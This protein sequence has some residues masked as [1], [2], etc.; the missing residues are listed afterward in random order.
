MGLPYTFQFL[1][2]QDLNQPLARFEYDRRK[3]PASS[4]T[5]DLYDAIERRVTNRQPFDGTMLAKATLETLQVTAQTHGGFCQLWSLE[6]PKDKK[7]AAQILGKADR[8]RLHHKALHRQLF[9]ELRW[10][11]KAAERSQ[12]GIDIQTLELS[13][14]ALLA[15]ATLSRYPIARTFPRK[16][17][18]ALPASALL[19]CSHFCCLGL[20]QSITPETLFMAGRVLQQ[21]WLKATCLE[22]ALQ[23][24]TVLPFFLIRAL[25]FPGTGFNPQEE[26]EINALGKDLRNL[27]RLPQESFPLFLFRLSQAAPPSTRSLR[28]DWDTFTVK[29]A[30]L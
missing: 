12:D 5:A 6:D 22:L 17:V 2:Y 24:W 10:N 9:G 19:G 14:P 1:G 23:P 11:R 18:E 3:D 27:F 29:C 7:R 16:A 25:F 15:L 13:L 30:S 28:L 8:I 4:P 21:V 20:N 26:L